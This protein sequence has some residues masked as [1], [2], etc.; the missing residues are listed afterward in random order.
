MAHTLAQARAW[1]STLKT[2]RP[3]LTALF[4]GGTS[5]IGRS[6]AIRLAG[7]IAKPTIYIVGRNEKAGAEILEEMKTANKD[8]SY[9]MIS[10][11]VSDLRTVDT[12]CKD[13]KTKI[14]GLDLLFLTSGGVTFSKKGKV[15][16]LRPGVPL[17]RRY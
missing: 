11:D 10:A 1:N 17:P 15:I 16:L 12:V 14:K 13:L 9:F 2:A 8:G 5:G 4:V 6:A 3:D 7:S